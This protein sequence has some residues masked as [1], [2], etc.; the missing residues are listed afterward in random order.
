MSETTDAVIEDA[1][2]IA[3][4]IV[5]STISPYLGAKQIWRQLRDADFQGHEL[6]PF[7]Y[8]FDE[9]EERPEDRP[10]FD[11]AIR[12]AARRLLATNTAL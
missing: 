4:Q 3:Q 1:K 8:C 2:V 9:W 11:N 6:D 5:D 7:I 12:D 10:F